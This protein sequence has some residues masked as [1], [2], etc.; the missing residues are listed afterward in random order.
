MVTAGVPQTL[1][2]YRLELAHFGNSGQWRAALDLLSELKQAGL[3]PDAKIYNGV[4]D[5]FAQSTEWREAGNVMKEM[6]RAGHALHA[7][8]FRGVIV[9]ASNAGEWRVA[10]RIFKRMQSLGVERSCRSPVIFNSVTAACGVAGRWEE[11]LYALRLTL[12]DG[13]VPTFIAYNATLGALGKAGRWQHAQRLLKDMRRSAQ[14]AERGGSTT[15]L[16]GAVRLLPPDVY[17]YTSVIDACAK[18]G[19]L[20]RALEVFEEMRRFGV[21]PSLVT[22][23][24][25]ISACGARG[26]W[27][28]ALS[29][30]AQMAESGIVP[31]DVTLS[32]TIAACEAGGEWDKVALRLREMG[33]GGSVVARLSIIA[34]GRVGNWR[35]GLEVV[36]EMKALGAPRSVHVYNALIEALVVR[37]R[38]RRVSVAAE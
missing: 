2:C 24:T 38:R 35:G 22:F 17:S 9:A 31:D 21:S 29:F 1:N 19:E 14:D 34:C 10:W 27:Q 26:D 15:R 7:R 33:T 3:T 13:M 37:P 28:R 16:R 23:N 12:R 20:E 30:V 4:L 5:S 25:L 8:S 6:E 18:A 36:E 32:V 11:A